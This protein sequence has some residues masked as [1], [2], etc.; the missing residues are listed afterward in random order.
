[1]LKS[2]IGLTI[3]LAL[4]LSFL[5]SRSQGASSSANVGH[6]SPIPGLCP[7]QTPEE[8]QEFLEH[9]AGDEKWVETCEDST[10]DAD[11]YKFVKENI[12]SIFDRCQGFLAEHEGIARCTQNMRHFTPFWLKQHDV[13]SYGF[14]N[15][16][17]A[18]LAAED[19][20][21][22]PKDMMRVP[23]SIISALPY[24]KD[25]EQAARDNGYQYLTHTSAIDGFRT[26]IFI[27]DPEGRFDKWML[28]NLKSGNSKVQDKTQFSVLVV[29]KKEASGRLLPQVRL[30]F[31]D[32]TIA[33]NEGQAGYRLDL[34]ENGNG[35][36]FSCHSNGVRQL[37]PLHTAVLEAQPVKGE[38]IANTHDFAFQR[39]MQFNRKLRSYGTPD[40]NGNVIPENI[41]PALGAKQGCMD[42]HNG[43]SRAPLTVF[44][45]PKQVEQKMYHELSMPPD[46]GLPELMEWRQMN[47]AS[48]APTQIRQA[49]D[50]L[51]EAHGMHAALAKNF[52]S[53]RLP[54]LKDWFLETTCR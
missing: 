21:D 54:A 1:M 19:A 9:Y 2:A 22:K 5:T 49:D 46:T 35:K 13:D 48:L 52:E 3:I 33:R 8:W 41:G 7:Y 17:H 53:S 20:S 23:D 42:C 27:P 29:Q 38:T 28:L 11:Y 6:Q 39:L 31:R 15:D 47:Q 32:Y 24:Q 26:F 37:I 50:T 51:Q 44:A 16:N 10:C 30:N 18:Y 34:N 14:M 36:C 45:S 43:A 4:A 25:V 12:Q 40:W